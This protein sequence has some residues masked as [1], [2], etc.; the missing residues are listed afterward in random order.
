MNVWITKVKTAKII[1]AVS[2]IIIIK[3]IA[4]NTKQNYHTY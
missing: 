1:N 2:L 3:E 4:I